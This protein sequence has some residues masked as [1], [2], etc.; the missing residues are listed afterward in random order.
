MQL[1]TAILDMLCDLGA[2]GEPDPL[3]EILD[4]Y[5]E[6][7]AQVLERLEAAVAADD[8]EAIRRAAHRLKGASANVG[9]R[10]LAARLAIV[11]Q[12]SDRGA[13]PA[14]RALVVEVREAF[15]ATLAALRAYE[16]NAST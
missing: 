9:A 2:P 12:T 8:P 15:P 10:G 7:A 6:D 14:L 16:P 13:T 5:E 3:A 1:D 4:V 11:E